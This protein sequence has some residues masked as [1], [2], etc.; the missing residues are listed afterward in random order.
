VGFRCDVA[1]SRG[2]GRCLAVCDLFLPSAGGVAADA[3]VKIQGQMV[4]AKSNGD[5]SGRLCGRRWM[6]NR[7][8]CMLGMGVQ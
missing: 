8:R 7:T 1:R 6:D 5:F 4:I 3:N 2:D